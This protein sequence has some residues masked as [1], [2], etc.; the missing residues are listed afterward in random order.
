MARGEGPTWAGGIA[1]YGAGLADLLAVPAGD[2]L[3]PRLNDFILAWDYLQRFGD[4]FADL[5]K[6]DRAAAGTYGLA[7]HDDARA[8]DAAGTASS[9]RR[10]S[11]RNRGRRE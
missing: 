2:L 8:A 10:G 11:R 3:T 1:R 5:G 7:L 6:P 9:S 4:V